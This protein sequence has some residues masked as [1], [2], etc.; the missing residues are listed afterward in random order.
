MKKFAATKIKIFF[1]S[2]TNVSAEYPSHQTAVQAHHC[3]NSAEWVA[4]HWAIFCRVWLTNKA[5][6][7]R[8][9]K[10]KCV[11][12]Y[13]PWYQY[14]STLTSWW[15]LPSQAMFSMTPFLP[16][17]DARSEALCL[18]LVLS[19][20]RLLLLGHATRDTYTAHCYS[21]DMTRVPLPPD[22]RYTETT[23]TPT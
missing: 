21:G 20:T 14:K 8:N 1:S 9:C 19:R 5:L 4:T 17:C 7:S 3:K 22:R 6:Q 23:D 15:I 10:A 12:L 13:Y 18:L 11:S 2:Q 16:T